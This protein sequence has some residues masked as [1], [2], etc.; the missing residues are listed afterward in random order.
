MEKDWLKNEDYL[1]NLR[2]YDECIDHY[3]RP[4]R[5]NHKQFDQFIKSS[6]PRRLCGEFLQQLRKNVLEGGLEFENFSL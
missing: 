3:W 4:L 5:D 6:E 1:K 2:K